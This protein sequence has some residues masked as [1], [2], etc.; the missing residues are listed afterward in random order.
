LVLN[1]FIIYSSNVLVLG[2]WLLALGS[3]F[4]TLNPSSVFKGNN[5]GFLL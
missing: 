2:S 3:W 5:H 4:L 1:P